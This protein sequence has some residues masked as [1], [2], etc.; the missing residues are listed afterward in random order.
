V[1]TLTADARPL[2]QKAGNVRHLTRRS[3]LNTTAALVAGAVILGLTT[4]CSSLTASRVQAFGPVKILSLGDMHLTDQKS[5]TYPRKVVRAMND[6]GGDLVLVCGDLGSKPT[7]A[8]LEL[9]RDVLDELK[10]PYYPVLGNHDALHAGEKEETLFREVFSLE[11]NSYHFTQKGIRFIGVDHGCGKAY[12]NNSVRPA[13]MAWLEK[14]LATIPDDQPIIFFSH[15]PFGKG[16]K[17]RT[18]NADDVHA[19]F[20]GKRLLAMI[21]GHFHGNTEQREN[22]V[23]M[24]TTA[25]SSGTRGNHDRTG[26][27]GFRVFRVDEDLNITTEFKEVK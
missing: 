10:M 23:L 11:Q 6:E 13:V 16:V 3:F 18:R 21:G 24:T 26:A 25:C 20:E 9:A 14:T 12:G 15:Y 2:A 4:G 17:Y 19:L 22:G 7:R 5:A 1:V 27:K 8:E